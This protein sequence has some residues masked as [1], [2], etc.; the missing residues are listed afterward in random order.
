M[1][2]AQEISLAVMWAS[3]WEGRLAWEEVWEEKALDPSPR[4][5]QPEAPA[6]AHSSARRW[7]LQSE[8]V[9][10]EVVAS[11]SVVVASAA[12]ELGSSSAWA[13]GRL[14]SWYR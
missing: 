6:L 12:A 1:Q 8:T 13:T 7:D 3:M 2:W 9:L 4:M 11:A 5:R 10:V 14:D